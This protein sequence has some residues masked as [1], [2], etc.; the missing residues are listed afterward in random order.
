MIK[1]NLIE[2]SEIKKVVTSRIKH[3]D[4]FIKLL[5]LIYLFLKEYFFKMKKG[6]KDNYVSITGYIIVNKILQPWQV[7]RQVFQKKY[8]TIYLNFLSSYTGNTGC[9]IN[10]IFI[11]F[12]RIS[13]L[14]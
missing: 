12:D 10:L 14:F 11:C 5:D 2:Y 3:I 8:E 7:A 6:C 1:T 4:S 13:V 9:R